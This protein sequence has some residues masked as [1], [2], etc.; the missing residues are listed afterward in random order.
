MK[1]RACIGGRIVT[2][3]RETSNRGEDEATEDLQGRQ[4]YQEGRPP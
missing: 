2:L 4:D 3:L 1:N